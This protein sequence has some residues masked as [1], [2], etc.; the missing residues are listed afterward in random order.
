MTET[1]VN[2]SAFSVTLRTT[3]YVDAPP[4]R[5]WQVLTDT[6]AYPEWNPLVCRLEGELVVGNRL[7]VDIQ[8]GKKPRTMTPTVVD[9]QP[10][11]S[12]AWLGRLGVRGL[13]DGR[14][15]FTVTPEGA[16][17]R[18]VQHEVLSGALTPV[19]RGLLTRDTPKAFAACNDALAA[20]AAG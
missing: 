4:A 11:R 1:E 12:F 7:T 14:H 20:R 2:T 17:S 9:V 15:S 3:T 16:G 19:L 5:V 8:P 13:L 6:A 10:G 18:L